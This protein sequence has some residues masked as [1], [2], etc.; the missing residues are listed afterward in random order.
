MADRAKHAFGMLENIDSALSN[1]TIDSYD[2]LFVKDANGKPYVGW[3]DKDGNKVIVDDSAELAELE[4]QLS[5]KA[6]A[7][8]VNSRIEEAVAEAISISNAYADKKIA[9][10]ETTK[11][12]ISHKPNGVRV[13]FRDKEIRIMCPANTEWALQQSGEGA[14]K[15]KYYLGFKAYAPNDAVSFKEDLAKSISDTTMYY[16]E[17]NDFA[18]IDSNGRKY[19]IVWLPVAV[20]DEANG[21][22]IYYGTKSTTDK[23]I[24][25]HYSVEWYDAN[26]V[27]I[28][29]DCIR[30]NLSNE[31]C[32]SSIEP[33]YMGEMMKEFETMVDEKIAEADSVYEIIEF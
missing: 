18:G 22:W 19:S 26:G 24:G 4:T 5:T 10:T 30:I 13:D 12:E 1:G 28:A 15:N 6:N 31:N 23:F 21:T 33:C 3:I 16:F 32:H 7:E 25:W 11:Y 27:V 17:N 14:E 20:Y 2:I 29:S 8:D 9:T